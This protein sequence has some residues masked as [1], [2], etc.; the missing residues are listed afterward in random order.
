[1]RGLLKL[2]VKID[3]SRFKLH[4][5]KAAMMLLVLLIA[6]AGLGYGIPA[7]IAHHFR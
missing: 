4:R 3:A 5:L 7:L 1:M 2:M 6:F